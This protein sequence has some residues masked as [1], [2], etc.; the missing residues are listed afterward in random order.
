MK[1]IKTLILDA[2]GVLVYPLHGNW[3]IPVKYRELLGAHAADIPGEKWLEACQ[4]E[5]LVV[6]EDVYVENME[7]EY[8]CRLEFLKRIGARLGWELEHDAYAALA[9]D[10]TYNT[11]RYVWYADCAQWLNTWNQEMKTGMLSDAMPSFRYV[12]DHSDYRKCFDAIV[13]STEIGTAK[14]DPRMYGTVCAQL[15]ADPAECLFVDDRECNLRGAI[16]CGIHAV[17]MCR[18]GLE[19]WD[20]PYV[21]DLAEL[22]NYMEGLN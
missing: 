5:A 6:R 13:I 11:G 8:A 3:N 14:P 12:V 1:K 17:Q 10:F 2:G 7:A 4:A 21:R 16:A 15:G 9:E 20:G 19:P 18:D 22:N